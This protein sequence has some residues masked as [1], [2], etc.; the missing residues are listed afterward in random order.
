LNITLINILLRLDN[1]LQNGVDD[2]DGTVG[3]F[4]EDTVDVLKDFVKYD[5]KVKESLRILVGIS[6]CFGWE[7]SLVKMIT[8]N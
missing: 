5:V 2:S 4:I 8:D 6:S 1:K 3:G 7:E